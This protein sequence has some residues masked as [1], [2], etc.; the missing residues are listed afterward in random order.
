MFLLFAMWNWIII[1]STFSLL[2]TYNID[3]WEFTK[4][5]EIH[6]IA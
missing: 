1:R 2:Q 3:V 6:V 5:V 4:D